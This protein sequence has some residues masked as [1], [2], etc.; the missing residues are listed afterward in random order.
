MNRERAH[1]SNFSPADIGAVLATVVCWGTGNGIGRADDALTDSTSFETLRGRVVGS[2][3]GSTVLLSASNA[4]YNTR[5]DFVSGA[6]VVSPVVDTSRLVF[7]SEFCGPSAAAAIGAD[8][9][10]KQ[11]NKSAVTMDRAVDRR[12]SLNILH[13]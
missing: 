9:E 3:G 7:L 11:V 12:F 1:A 2:S 4:A 8:S 6:A 13:L 5:G 10:T